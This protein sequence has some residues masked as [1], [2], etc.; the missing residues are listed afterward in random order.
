MAMSSA[1]SK[2]TVREMDVLNILWKS[3]RPLIAS[4]ITKAIRGQTINAIQTLLRSLLK[5]G[6]VEVDGIVYSGTVLSR[7]YKATE[8]SKEQMLVSM[9]KQYEDLR[10]C[11][12]VSRLFTA[13]LDS[14]EDID[15]IENLEAY[16]KEKK[17]QLMKE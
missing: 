13:L 17:E 10:H 7:S 1:R 12:P 6:Y 2:I 4:E 16:I 14:E 15:V 9:Q 8:L 5:K 11:M 3:D